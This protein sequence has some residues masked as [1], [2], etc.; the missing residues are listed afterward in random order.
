MPTDSLRQVR[1]ILVGSGLTPESIGGVV[2]A[3]LLARRYGAALHLVHVVEP[4]SELTE[5]AIPGLA[6]KHVQQAEEELRLFCQSHG[7]AEG[8]TLH[9]LR[10]DPESEILS[11]RARLHADLI[12]VGRYGKGGLKRGRLGS[13]ADRL[14]RASPVSVVV[15]LPEFRGEI[16][17]VGMACDLHAENDE[18]LIRAVEVASRLGV[19]EVVLLGSYEVPSG[20]HMVLTWEEA[21]EKIAHALR[22]HADAMIARVARV[23]PGVAIRVRIEEGPPASRIPALALEERLDLLVLGTHTRTAPAQ[24]LLGRI[25]EKIIDA[26]GCSVWAEKSPRR[27]QRFIDALTHL[28]D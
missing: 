4:V 16:Q 14:L 24:V 10:G 17:R 12:V 23:A 5:Q 11:L 25:S 19:P 3:Q 2:T 26:A 22:E 13:V 20:Y 8:V 21:C 15:A 27:Y 28:L 6:E 9:V 7:L 18:F 1:T